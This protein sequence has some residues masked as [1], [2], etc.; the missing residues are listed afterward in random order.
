MPDEHAEKPKPPESYVNRTQR[1]LND[2]HKAFRQ[3]WKMGVVIV[4]VLGV[5][6]AYELG[7]FPKKKDDPKDLSANIIKMAAQYEDLN[8]RY[9]RLQ[10]ESQNKRTPPR[11]P[12]SR[13]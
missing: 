5:F 3:S 6:A 9:Q 8:A 2:L 4:V 7:L 1:E 13:T 12:R 10:E 11:T